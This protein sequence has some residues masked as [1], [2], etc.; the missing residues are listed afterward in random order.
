MTTEKIIL[1]SVGT[2]AVSISA[3]YL[4]NENFRARVDAMWDKMVAGIKSEEQLHLDAAF[5]DIYSGDG[6]DDHEQEF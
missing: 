1:L 6:N 4:L 3:L 2:I 5:T